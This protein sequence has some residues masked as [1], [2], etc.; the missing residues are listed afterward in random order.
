MRKS[1]RVYLYRF[2]FSPPAHDIIFT[3]RRDRRPTTVGGPRRADDR[4]PTVT[5]AL[6]AVECSGDGRAHNSSKRITRQL[7]AGPAVLFGRFGV[8]A[9]CLCIYLSTIIHVHR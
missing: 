7:S 3:R 4:R 6:L 5:D 8:G 9:R 1:S 2:I